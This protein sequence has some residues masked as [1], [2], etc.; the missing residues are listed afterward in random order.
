MGHVGSHGGPWS[1]S[2]KSAPA[3]AN[4]VSLSS[5]ATMID[6]STKL[7]DTRKMPKKTGAA[8]YR[9]A[10]NLSSKSYGNLKW[11]VLEKVAPQDLLSRPPH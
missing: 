9:A 1:R 4:M 2:R 7:M 5:G 10:R 8:G 6:M 3:L 11:D